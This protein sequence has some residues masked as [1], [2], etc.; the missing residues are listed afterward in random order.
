M[1]CT[2]DIFILQTHI[3]C[4]SFIIN[5]TYFLWNFFPYWSICYWLSPIWVHRSHFILLNCYIYY[6]LILV[7]CWWTLIVPFF[8]IADKCYSKH[9]GIYIF[10]HKKGNTL[11]GWILDMDLNWQTC[12]SGC[13]LN[14]YQ[15]VSTNSIWESSF[16]PTLYRFPMF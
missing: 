4:A 8:A 7:H 16:L 14:Y 9:P 5:K 11:I 13:L 1:F 10:M 12:S 2:E 6:C 3:V 15:T